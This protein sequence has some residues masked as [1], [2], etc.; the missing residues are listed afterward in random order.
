MARTHLAD[1]RRKDQEERQSYYP[2]DRIA[3]MSWTGT[4]S[5]DM[6]AL[7]KY[8]EG[9]I[10]FDTLRL[11]VAANNFLDDYFE[12]HMVPAD[13]MRNLLRF[14]G[15]ERPDANANIQ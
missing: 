14:T 8:R 9:N 15:W 6:I 2:K 13:A 7:R 12:D 10:T 3:L 4:V 1:L 5:A 11:M